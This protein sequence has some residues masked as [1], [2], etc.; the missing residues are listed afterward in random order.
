MSAKSRAIGWWVGRA[1]DG[2]AFEKRCARGL[3]WYG[4]QVERV[5][6]SG[7]QGVDLIA[8]RGAARVAVQCKYR[9]MKDGLDNK[10]VQEVYLGAQVW[11]CSGAAC[12]TNG[13][14][15]MSAG[16]AANGR[17]Q[18]LGVTELGRLAGRGRWTRGAVRWVG[19]VGAVGLVWV[20][21]VSRPG[22]I[23]PDPRFHPTAAPVVARTVSPEVGSTPVVMPSEGR[24]VQCVRWSGRMRVGG[25]R[26]KYEELFNVCMSGR[27]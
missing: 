3:R 11:R 19:V 9:S 27:T 16:V 5:G 13:W 10:A 17:V 20:V 23:G 4:W 26:R 21:V 24:V 8:T 6:G 25:D 22:K 14:Y 15:R 2:L 1:R 12:I 7:D 18:L